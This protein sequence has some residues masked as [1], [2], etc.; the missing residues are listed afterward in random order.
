LTDTWKKKETTACPASCTA[1]LNRQLLANLRNL[2]S[3]SWLVIGRNFFT[4]A[5]TRYRKTYP[6]KS[7]PTTSRY[8]TWLEKSTSFSLCFSNDSARL[9]PPAAVQTSDIPNKTLDVSTG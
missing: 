6:T 4:M 1:V 9:P 8:A 7:V 2:A 3:S 5:S